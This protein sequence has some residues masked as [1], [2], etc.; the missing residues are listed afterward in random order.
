[1]F[2]N[3]ISVKHLLSLFV[4]VG[5]EEHEDDVNG[6]HYINQNVRYVLSYIIGTIMI[7][8]ISDRIRHVD[9]VVYCENQDKYVPFLLSPIFE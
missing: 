3:F 5:C 6:E 4:F 1:M 7:L 2:T 8:V 9:A